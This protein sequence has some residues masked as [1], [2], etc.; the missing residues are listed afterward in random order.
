MD[1]SSSTWAIDENIDIPFRSPRAANEGQPAT[2]VIVHPCNGTSLLGATKAAELGIV[3]PILVGPAA[4]IAAVAA[5]HKLA[6]LCSACRRRARANW[7]EPHLD[8]PR[9]RT[10]RDHQAGSRQRFQ[11]H[12]RYHLLR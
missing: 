2:M 4:K 9:P 5:R 12:P 3:N 10:A 1:V 6:Y 8:R 7:L 11:R